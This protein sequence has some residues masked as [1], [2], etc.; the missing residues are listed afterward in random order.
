MTAV[1]KLGD[2]AVI[3]IAL[4]VILLIIPSTRKIGFAGALALI[5]SFLAN[6]VIFKRVFE[7]PRP[8][9]DMPDFKLLIHPLTSFSF[10][11]G[12][13]AHSFA[14]AGV[15]SHYLRR[16]SVLFFVLAGLIAFSRVYL[17]MHYLTDVLAGALFGLLW[18]FLAVRF[19][20]RLCPYLVRLFGRGKAR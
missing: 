13:A 12:H 10:P 5:I 18:S 4:T 3:W 9:M 19:A 1:T 7:R 16:W 2:M 8:Y 17:N 15:F 11:S 14:A 6:D 20:D